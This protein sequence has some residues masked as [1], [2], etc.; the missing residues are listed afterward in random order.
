M[1]WRAL[2]WDT[3]RESESIVDAN[4]NLD[5]ATISEKFCESIRLNDDKSAT[6]KKEMSFHWKTS[7]SF[8]HFVA[9]CPD[10]ILLFSSF[11]CADILTIHYIWIFN[12]SISHAYKNENRHM[13]IY[14]K[15]KTCIRIRM[16]T[17]IP[18]YTYIFV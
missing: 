15:F 16:N 6:T 1:F 13:Q 9:I 11:D 17:C 12:T 14:S 18:T 10:L 8:H 3:S 2:H 5:S 7:S 4:F